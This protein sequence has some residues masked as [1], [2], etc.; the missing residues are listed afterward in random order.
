MRKINLQAHGAMVT[1]QPGVGCA[2]PHMMSLHHTHTY[3]V[4][5][6]P[7]LRYCGLWPCGLTEPSLLSQFS[8]LDGVMCSTAMEQLSP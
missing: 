1:H 8:A 7:L 5:V 2:T 6:S 3:G 4:V